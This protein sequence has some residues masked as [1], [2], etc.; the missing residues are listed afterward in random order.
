LDKFLQLP[1]NP[2]VKPGLDSPTSLNILSDMGQILPPDNR[3]SDRLAFFENHLAGFVIDFFDSRPLFAEG[4]AKQPYFWT[5]NG[6]DGEVPRRPRPFPYLQ[7][8]D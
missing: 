8:G 5:L 7:W 4:F 3:R 6:A 1:E 2:T